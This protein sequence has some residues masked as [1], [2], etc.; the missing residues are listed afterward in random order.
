MAG[1]GGLAGA[2][3]AERLVG[4]WRRSAPV[5]D[6]L[7]LGVTFD[8]ARRTGRIEAGRARAPIAG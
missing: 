8:A 7:P 6:G 5:P 2:A 4:G 1:S 3:A